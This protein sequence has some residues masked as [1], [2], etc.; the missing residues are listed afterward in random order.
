MSM[1]RADQ[2]QSW[3]PED[4]GKMLDLVVQAKSVAA[5]ASTLF[6]TNKQKV[7][8]PLWVADPA[9]GW[10]NELDEITAADGDTDEVEVTPSKTAGLTLVSN[11]LA[12]DSDPAVA[13]QIASALA[14]QIAHAIDAAYFANTTAKGPNGL[15]SLASTAVDPGTSVANLD[16]FVSARYA[17]EAHGAKLTHWLLSP[18]VAETLSKLKIQ[19]GS[20]QSLIQFVEDGITVAGLPV[21]TSTHVDADTVAWGVDKTQQR[22]V[23]RSGTTV[24]RFD[25][26]T[27]DGLYIRAISRIGVGFLNPAGVVRLYH[28]S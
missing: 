17:A 28:A 12:D 13:N 11:E 24:E 19:S 2:A 4:F 22:Y 18:A 16:A 14:N 23:L 21:I 1:K 8:F 25:S 10:Y 20:N 5:L 6:P 15:L 9:V 27:N 26:V 3:L 7:A